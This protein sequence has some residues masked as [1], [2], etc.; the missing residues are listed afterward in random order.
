MGGVGHHERKLGFHQME[1]EQ[2]Q[3]INSAWKNGEGNPSGFRNPGGGEPLTAVCT[4]G[5]W[6]FG[7][8]KKFEQGGGGYRQL[9]VKIWGEC[10]GEPCTPKA[11][12]GMDKKRLSRGKKPSVGGLM[13][14]ICQL[15]VAVDFGTSVGRVKRPNAG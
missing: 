5:H 8:G 4:G 15:P 6:G 13:E 11:V 14:N 3:R 1:R 9:K 10:G 7:T 2:I 12:W